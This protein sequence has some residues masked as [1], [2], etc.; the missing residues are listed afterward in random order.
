MEI[1]LRLKVYEKYEKESVGIS[2]TQKEMH[3][4][5]EQTLPAKRRR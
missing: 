5:E 2:R 1:S 3:D 4:V